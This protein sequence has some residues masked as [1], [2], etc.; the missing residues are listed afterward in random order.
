MKLWRSGIIISALGFL[1]GLGNYWFQGLIARRLQESGEFGL[2]GSTLYLV[3]LLGLPLAIVGTSLVHYIAHYR[4]HDDTARLHGL[5]ASYQR[6]LLRATVV[7]TILAIV[8]AQP[9]SKFFGFRPT[10][11][12]AA[13]GV[14][15]I[16]A[17]A[18][19]A[20]ALCQGMAWFKR[21]AIIGLFGVGLR[22]GFG[23]VMTAKY[24]TAEVAVMATAFSL[25]ANLVLLYWRKDIF[26]KGEQQ[27]SPWD[28]NFVKF[29]VIATAILGG[30][31]LFTK[32]D[33]LVAKRFFDKPALDS[34]T[35]AGLLGRSLVLVV[36]PL[37]TVVFTSRSG[38]QN[39]QALGDQKILLGLYAV[40]LAA[41]AA[42]LYLLR[43]IFVALLFGKV[44]P[45]ASV[46]VGRLTITMAAVGLSQAIGMWSLASRWYRL[47]LLYGALGLAY[48]IT[49][50]LHG[51]TPGDL[52]TVMPIAAAVTFAV[53]CIAWLVQ[54]KRE[55]TPTD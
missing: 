17:W 20:L 36:G 24:P 3:E 35:A 4:A 33:N 16:A 6:F 49:L 10:I 23:Y 46:M 26:K 28:R 32:G 43:E 51:Q 55:P 41:G 31:F 25:L 38:K 34:Y 21:V 18:G 54:L 8:I 19:Y 48:W 44:T 7:G 45:E 15:L 47:S 12:V 53:L 37:L 39:S 13:I 2:V 9:V 50:L 27:V 30:T 40:G 11:T 29:L 52:L 1:G 5:I 14:L 42:V 22:I